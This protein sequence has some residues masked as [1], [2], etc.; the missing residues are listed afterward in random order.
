MTQRKGLYAFALGE[1]LALNGRHN[2]AAGRPV[3]A[4]SSIENPPVWRKQ[5]LVDGQS[6]VNPPRGRNAVR[7]T[8]ITVA[9]ANSPI[10]SSGFK[11]IWEEN[12]CWTRQCWYPLV[13]AISQIG[14]ASGFP[15]RFRVEAACEPTF[16]NAQL[17]FE[18]TQSDFPNPG[19]APLVL[20]MNRAS[21]LHSYHRN[22]LVAENWR[23][24]L[25]FGRASGLQ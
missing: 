6:I 1:L 12:G 23:L 9:S 2:L 15:V 10:A 11:S 18:A 14:A 21:T 17:I 25:R 3:T 22:A 19:D 4:N 13:P 24:R 5:N 8:A 20:P 16:R 7:A